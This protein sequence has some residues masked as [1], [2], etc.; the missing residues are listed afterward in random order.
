MGCEVRG[1]KI[2]DRMNVSEKANQTARGHVT[3]VAGGSVFADVDNT[4]SFTAAQV[5]AEAYA[6]DTSRVPSHIGFLYGDALESEFSFGTDRDMS[7]GS[8]GAEIADKGMN[9]Q[10]AKLSR[11][12]QVDGGSVV[13]SAVTRSSGAELLYSGQAY[14]SSDF[15][16]GKTVYQVLLLGRGRCPG[17]W[18]V[19]AR[20]DL[21]RAGN[22]R[23]KPADYELSV[24]WKITFK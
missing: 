23:Q 20:A 1:R 4:S 24:D 14:S 8:I 15:V 19:L 13:F 9:V 12:P 22:Y 7:V 3:A 6:G 2:G 11:R 10:V 18:A 16:E 5:L 17:E 21:G